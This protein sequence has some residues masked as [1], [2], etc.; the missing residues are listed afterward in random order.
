[1]STV[2]EK[3]QKLLAMAR[4]GRGNEHEEEIALKM[5]E[6]MM[7]QHNIDIADLEQ[8]S[9][10]PAAYNWRSITLPM[11]EKAAR[12]TWRPLWVGFLLTGVAQF[13]DCK[14]E[15]VNTQE[16]GC[17]AKFSGDEVDIEYAAWLFKFLRDIGYAEGHSVSGKERDS[18]RKGFAIRV[19]HRMRVMRAERDQA[20]K[21]AVTKSGSTALMVVNNKIALRN[22]QFGKMRTRST[23]VNTPSSNG[24]HLGTRAGDRV[25]FNRPIGGSGSPKQL[26]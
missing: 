2:R 26:S 12:M 20:M 9:G 15:Y 22:E 16:Y 8:S 18:F 11:G 21:A 5:A 13:T 1:M 10:K 25:Q 24:F 3:I 14:G 17:C 6:R 4:D 23:S 7:R 19:T